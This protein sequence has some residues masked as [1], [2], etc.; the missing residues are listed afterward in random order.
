MYIPELIFANYMTSSNYDDSE[1]RKVSGTHG[2]GVKLSSSFS[3]KSIIEIVNKGKYYKQVFEK[4]LFKINAPSIKEVGSDSKEY[5]KI[6]LYPDYARFGYNDGMS[7]DMYKVFKQ[8]VYESSATTNKN[9][10][11]H[12]NK[13]KVPFKDF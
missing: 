12:L 5:V 9:L 2:Y 1:Q 8:R 4:N 6:T 13:T 7:D 10:S 11:V 3:S